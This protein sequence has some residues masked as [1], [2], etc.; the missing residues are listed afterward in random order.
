VYSIRRRLILVLVA[1]FAGLIAVAGVYMES[2]LRG[3]VTEEFD[4][5]LLVKARALVALS[6]QENGQIEFDYEPGSM[7][8]YE[9]GERPEYFQLWLDNGTAL[10]RSGRLDQ[11]LPRTPSLSAQPEMHDVQLPD[12]RFGRAVQ[13][14]FIPRGPG[15]DDDPEE[16]VDPGQMDPAEG[17]HAVVLVVARSRERLDRLIARMRLTVFGAGAV[18][19]AL[20][21][22][23]VW[24]ALVSGFRPLEAI[25]A[26]VEALDAES[27]GTR[28]ELP[29]SARELAPIVHQLNAMLGRL[30][31]SFERERR[32]AGNVAHELRTPIAELRSLAEVGAKWPEDEA[33][34]TQFF[35]DVRDISGRMGT[36]VV[37][38]LL[39]AR[40]QARVEKVQSRL[41]NL[42]E[43]V[44][45]SWSKQAPRASR[46]RLRLHLELPDDLV[47]E[48]D[49]D[50][51]A[52]IL[53]NLFDNAASY[54]SE[55]CEIRCVG[56]VS[57]PRFRLDV[58]NP[59]EPLD[60][61]DI[62]NL[63]EPFWRKDKARS[64]GE[65]AGIGLS[66]VSALAGL[67][68]LV[69]EFAQG[70]NGTFRA[71]LTGPLRKAPQA[72]EEG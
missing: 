40:C 69:V 50:K 36:L 45:A 39:L 2:L 46:R 58:T 41:S 20:A 4:A 48:T 31:H 6:E 8:E 34:V 28:I 23:F 65:H 10:F 13:L 11:D 21:A 57:G 17:E 55:E 18:A 7:P 61:D 32:F 71:T 29:R 54:A 9:R 14:T 5:A 60:P 72:G 24:Q 44:Q 59:C 3:Q 16:S 12:G 19:C 33:A 22:L 64:S 63:T 67:L 47:V 15:E 62:G 70:P 37:D 43:L 27:L 49:P 38:L 42:K 68:G 26:Q 25:A 1:G 52:I 56:T 30:E 66:L 35:E 51:L 53:A